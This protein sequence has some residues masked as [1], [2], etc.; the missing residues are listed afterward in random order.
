E[1]CRLVH[2]GAGMPTPSTHVA[3]CLA[4]TKAISTSRTVEE[5]YDAAL[6]ALRSGIGVQRAAILLFDPDGVMRFKAHRGLSEEY[7]R[8]VEGHTPWA[9]DSHDPQPIWVS[10]VAVDPSVAS[11]REI[12][13]A[14]QIAALGFIPLI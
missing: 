13:T 6:D 10:D 11:Y 5:I 7:R 1:L 8:A 9:P 4:L 2:N 12:F 14:E 3:T